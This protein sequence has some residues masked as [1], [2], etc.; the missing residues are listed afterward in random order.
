MKASLNHFQN[1]VIF[2]RDIIGLDTSSGGA[3]WLRIDV[4]DQLVGGTLGFGPR[5]TRILA[6]IF[7]NSV[8]EPTCNDRRCRNVL[9]KRAVRGR[10]EF[11]SAVAAGADQESRTKD[12]GATTGP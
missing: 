12:Q 4:C 2:S 9:Q 11:T 6:A 7:A 8:R 5:A 3:I 10:R 1:A